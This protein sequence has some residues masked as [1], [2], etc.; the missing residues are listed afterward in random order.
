[1]AVGGGSALA[2]E[3]SKPG[4]K[5]CCAVD[6]SGAPALQDETEDRAA[7]DEHGWPADA[8]LHRT[9]CTETACLACGRPVPVPPSRVVARRA[10]ARSAA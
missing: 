6:G 4:R 3:A 10:V 5:L 8:F 9:Y 2:R 1:M 7:H